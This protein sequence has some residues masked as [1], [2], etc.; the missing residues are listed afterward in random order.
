M[1]VRLKNI[2]RHLAM[3]V[4]TASCSTLALAAEPQHGG[5]LKLVGTADLDHFDPTSAALVTTNNF[6][7][8]VSRQLISYDA[9]VDETKQI[10]P[11]GDLAVAVPQPTNGGLTYTFTLRDGVTWNT[12]SG[13]RPITS[14]DFARGMKRMCNPA[15]G[16]AG[17][18]YY[19]DLIKGMK[20]FCDGFA[21]V[22]PVVADMKAYVQGTEISGI[23]TPDDKTIVIT[24]TEPAGDF[25]YMLSLTA[26]APAPIEV[27][28]YMPDGPDYRS[29]FISSGPYSVGAYTPDSSLQLVRNPS[30]KPESDPLR[31]AYVDQ[32]D[33][34]F[35]IPADAAIQQ[36]QAGDADM[37][38]DVVIP[39]AILNMLM[40]A[41]DTKLL[42]IS[43]GRTSFIFI[44][45]VSGN[46]NGAL[47]NPKLRQALNYAI[48]KAALVQQ[49]GGKTLAKQQNGIFGPGVLG[50]HEFDLYASKNGAGDVDKAKALLAEAGFPNGITLKMPYRNVG[51]Q[52]AV[53]QTIQ[54]SMKKAGITLD[55]IPVAPADYYSKFMTNPLNTKEGNWDIAPVGWAPDWVGGA[56]RSVFQPQFS[57]T[58]T[59]Q[60]YN[61]TDYN[62][63]E[64]NVLAAQAINA[65]TPDQ[66]AKLWG[67][68]DELVMKDA[69]IIP[70]VAEKVVLYRSAA[71]QNFL[72]Y[73]LGGQGDWTNVWLSR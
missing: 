71:V 66:V 20:S 8:A 49:I 46:N 32:I 18:T 13:A 55:L 64:A 50:Y 12:P 26:A 56:A 61:Y 47:K 65:T 30:W 14:K 37:V 15:L 57:Y 38:Y 33:I 62:N 28:D 16:S 2:A 60:T 29:H 63:P 45:T 22:K 59:H 27:L 23:E 1:G 42:P 21:K 17:L 36:L 58:G 40:V 69:P 53:A 4:L 10:E 34:T 48:D 35:G 43:T 39:P 67:Q 54:A 52:P 72:P 3:A 9:S 24:L 25:I 51:Y 73:A 44:N 7:R 31:K 68:V 70:Y 6:L 5:V 41:G 11:K 19:V